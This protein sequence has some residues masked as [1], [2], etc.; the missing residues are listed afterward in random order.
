[1]QQRVARVKYSS[2]LPKESA[3]TQA[4]EIGANLTRMLQETPRQEGKGKQGLQIDAERYPRTAEMDAR[5][6]TP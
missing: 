6:K 4:L 5:L 2:H 1:M 3:M